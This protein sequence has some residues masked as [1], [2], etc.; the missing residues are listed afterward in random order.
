VTFFTGDGAQVPAF[1]PFDG[2]AL[3][4]A[5]LPTAHPGIVA[6]QPAVLNQPAPASAA[7]TFPLGQPAMLNQPTTEA[8]RQQAAATIQ[9]LY[10]WLEAVV[11]MLPQLGVLV[12][13]LV[14]AVQQYETQQYG[15]S[16]Q[17]ALVVAQSAQQVQLSVPGLPS[18]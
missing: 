9:R 10:R 1:T 2:V 13:A 18:L 7:P 6:S 12:P 4:S 11:P 5:A 16:L 8:M 3:L 15:P 17:Q 14:T